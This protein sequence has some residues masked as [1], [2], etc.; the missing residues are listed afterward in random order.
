MTPLKRMGVP[1]EI[2]EA[3][4]FLASD[5]GGYIT[6]QVLQVDGGWLMTG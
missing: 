1:D 6:G 4:L 3:T 2:A 5:G